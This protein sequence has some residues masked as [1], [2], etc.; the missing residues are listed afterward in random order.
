MRLALLRLRPRMLGW[1]SMIP[2]ARQGLARWEL[3]NHRAGLGVLCARMGAA[4]FHRSS[5]R[6]GGC[7]AGRCQ[8]AAI[9]KIPRIGVLWHVGNEEEEALYLGALRQGFSELGYVEGKNFVL[10]NRFAAEQYER[11]NALAAELVK[12]NV[13]ILVAV[14][15]AAQEATPTIPVVFVVVSDPVGLIAVTFLQPSEQKTV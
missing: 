9:P 14:A 4:G 12:A 3:V 1:R 7:V 11:F 10:E 15:R 6:G 13:D 5:R 2:Q 8:R